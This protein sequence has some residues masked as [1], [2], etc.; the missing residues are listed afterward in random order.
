MQLQLAAA[1]LILAAFP[2]LWYGLP[3]TYRQREKL[4]A[5][6]LARADWA[7]GRPG[8]T[9]SGTP[10]PSGPGALAGP[11]GG[12]GVGA[13]AT[14]AATG[15]APGGSTGAAASAPGGAPGAPAGG[16]SG[17]PPVAP[18]APPIVLPEKDVG[19]VLLRLHI[20]QAQFHYPK[21]CR[22]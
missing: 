15:T 21:A 1:L 5:L 11:L 13:T 19:V 12:A 9:G 16:L 10:G 8:A 22:R 2:N 14:A 4:F 6:L 18:V 7:T 17:P 20:V 3:E